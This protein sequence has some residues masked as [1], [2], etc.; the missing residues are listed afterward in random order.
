[1]ALTDTPLAEAEFL[2]V[3]CE[4]NG[5]PGPACELTEVAAVLVGGGELH[6]SYDSLVAVQRPLARG[7]QRFTGITQAMLAG[8]PEPG[9]VLPEVLR[10]LEGRVLVAHNASFDR[11]VLRQAC[12]RCDLPWPE[13]PTL[14]TVSLARR[15]LPLQR[16]RRL[17]ALADALGIEP[18]VAHR[19]LPDARVCGQILCALLPRLVAHAA[20][21]GEAMSLLT[22]RRRRASTRT[23]R[24]SA[25]D[26]LALPAPACP[27]EPDFGALPSDPG[28][29]IFRD[30]QGE[31]LYVGKSVSIRSRA[32]SHF[33]PSTA[34]ARWRAHAEIVDYRPTA[35]ELGALVLENRLIKQLA[36]PGNQRLAGEPDGYVYVRCRLDIAFPV[37]EV[38]RT[39]AAGHAVN[40]GPVR[41]RRSAQELVEQLDSLFGLRHCSRRLTRREY[42]SAYGQMGRCLSPCLGDLDPNLYRRRLDE[43][44]ALITDGGQRL[45]DHLDT[46]MRA[47]AA[48]Q[49][50]ERAAALRRRRQR[51]GTLLQR[52]GGELAALHARPRLVIDRHPSQPRLEAFVLVGGRL[53]DWGELPG[54]DPAGPAAVA[55]ALR[56]AAS[57]SRDSA[58]PGLAV[59]EIDEVR[60]VGS[61]LASHPQASVLDLEPFPTPRALRL[62]LA[63]AASRAGTGLKSSS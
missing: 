58:P 5:A 48:E 46:Q 33:A 62:L 61:W 32:R 56:R 25:H 23:R 49:R 8:A 54:P 60:L 21:V 9:S 24:V 4:T 14:C 6:D 13:P 57:A 1:M 30:R 43:A 41:G 47:A 10:R 19:A 20:T 44:L 37:L 40:V 22:A 55:D 12:E 26:R 31:A 63:Q 36:P 35:S 45:L 7:V 18:D 17:G 39:P 15:L 34:P 2:A 38:A 59:E 29:Y 50:F 52:L 11:R 16:Q 53:V 27:A 28:V 42:P 51:L 3:D